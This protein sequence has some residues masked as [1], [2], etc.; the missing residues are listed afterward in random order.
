MTLDDVGPDNWRRPP[1]VPR[2]ERGAWSAE[3]LGAF[4][5]AT[6]EDRL[7]AMWLLSVT[8]GMRRSE[9]LGLPWWAVDLEV[10]PGRLAVAQT[11][12]VVDK[13]PVTK[14][15]A[16]LGPRRRPAADH[17]CTACATATRARRWPPASR[18]RSSPSGSGMP[19]PRSPPTSAST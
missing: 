5:E 18:S 11:V 4:L 16:P 9:L 6:S 10:K 15:F 12:V 14:R 13:H 3:E 8:T 17:P 19:A 1:R 7:A 2:Q